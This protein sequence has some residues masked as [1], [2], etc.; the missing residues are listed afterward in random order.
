MSKYIRV[1]TILTDFKI[2][3]NEI[4]L[5]RGAVIGN[6]KGQVNILFHNHVGEKEFRYSYPLIQYKRI[7]GKA[8]LVCIDEGTE[9]VGDFFS[10]KNLT[11]QI[12]DRNMNFCLEKIIPQNFR[13][14]I[15]DQPFLYCI[16]RWI[17][18]NTKNYNVYY[19][20]E[21]ISEK[22]TFLENIL[23][24]NILSFAKG[25]NVRFEGGVKCNIVEIIGTHKERVKGVVMGCFDV[26]FECNV[27][28]PDNIGLG[29]H[30]SIS[31]GVVKNITKENTK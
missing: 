15:W 5:F 29:K 30:V 12:G 25:I 31:Y 2:H 9:T 14:Q 27:S 23:T 16:K 10:S 24:G 4:P 26:L 19:Q 3:H 21:S 11:L 28:L 6:I 1:L 18:L 20:L 13:V 22:I 7:Y 8:A 17:P